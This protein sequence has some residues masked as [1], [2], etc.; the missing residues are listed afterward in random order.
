[1]DELGAGNSPRKSIESQRRSMKG[2]EGSA[3][4][5]GGKGNGKGDD[6]EGKAEEGKDLDLLGLDL[7]SDASPPKTEDLHHQPDFV[8]IVQPIGPVTQVTLTPQ[9]SANPLDLLDLDIAHA[10][11]VPPT[12]PPEQPKATSKGDFFDQ[13]SVRQDLF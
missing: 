11:I 3:G 10:R 12:Q 1:M 13:I 2:R 6:M 9:P 8:P 7:E 5:R 4:G